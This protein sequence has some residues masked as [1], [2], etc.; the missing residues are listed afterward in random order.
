MDSSRHLYNY[1]KGARSEMTREGYIQ[2]DSLKCRA[3]DEA[4]TC[5]E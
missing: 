2:R 1:A 3:T 5:W 4:G